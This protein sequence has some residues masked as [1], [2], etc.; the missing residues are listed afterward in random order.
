MLDSGEITNKGNIVTYENK[1][2]TKVPCD[3]VLYL[4][5]Y[6]VGRKNHISVVPGSV[7]SANVSNYVC[8]E[9]PENILGEINLS[10]IHI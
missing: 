6:D 5:R 10:L 7:N 9:S 3:R 2:L 8:Q 4:I 1:I